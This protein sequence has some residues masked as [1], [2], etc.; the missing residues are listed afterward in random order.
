MCV[1][2]RS[3]D[4]RQYSQSGNIVQWEWTHYSQ[5]GNAIENGYTT[6]SGDKKECRHY[7]EWRH[8]IVWRHYTVIMDTLYRLETL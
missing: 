4:W 2:I 8:Y 7:V 5:Y 1:S 3:T 6:Q